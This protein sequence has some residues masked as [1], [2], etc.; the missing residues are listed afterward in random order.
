MPIPSIVMDGE[1]LFDAIPSV[2]DLRA[3]LERRIAEHKDRNA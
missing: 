3:C 1:L 2:E